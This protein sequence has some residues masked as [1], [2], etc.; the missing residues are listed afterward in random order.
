MDAK[1]K[2]CAVVKADA[3]GLGA[4][5][6]ACAIDDL[7]DYFAVSS[8]EEFMEINR[9][10]SKPILLLDPIYKNITKL[11]RL[12]CE[13]CVSNKLQFEIILRLAKRNKNIKYKIH[14][15]F[16]T[17]MNRFGFDK[18]KDVLEIFEI[19]KK[20]QNISIIGV[21]SHFYAGNIQKFVILQSK[22]FLLLK[23][24][25]EANGFGNDIIF[26]IS[27]TEGFEYNQQFDMIRIGLGMFLYNNH[28]S[29]SL[30][31]N[32][33]EIRLLN[34]GEN[35]GYGNSYISDKKMKIAVVSIGYADGVLRC[36][37]NRGFVII[38]G[39]F[40]KILAV[41]MDSIIVDVS[42]VK[43]RLGDDVTLIGDNGGKQIFVC[44]FAKFCDTINYEVMTR[45]S[46]RVKRVYIG[47]KFYANHNGQV[48]SEKVKGG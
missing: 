12:N 32:I 37:A 26:H 10:V 7:V 39:L 21:F 25:L 20:A 34:K 9:H 43:V 48:Q 24:S 29:F 8:Q 36:M 6:V 42:G 16:N 38:N 47:G 17:G 4:S 30:E 40:C 1:I 33:V 11:A 41:C 2:F 19:I 35:I 22:K 15:A 18:I 13:F 27:N 46:R 3:Y 5:K 14:I 23:N 45:I 44:D 28:N 31:S